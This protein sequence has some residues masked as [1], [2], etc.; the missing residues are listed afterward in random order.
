MLDTGCKYAQIITTQSVSPENNIDWS[1]AT[2]ANL[3]SDNGQYA[4]VALD[5]PQISYRLKAQAFDFSAVPDG[6]TINGI[7]VE[8]DRKSSVANTVRDYRVQLLDA[9]GALV[10]SSKASTTY[11]PTSD[12]VATYGSSGD[13]WSASPTAAMVK[14]SDFGVVL[15]VKCAGG[16]FGTA[17]VDYIRMTVYYTEAVT[18]QPSRNYYPHILAH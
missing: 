14:D 1:G 6:A 3:N 5:Y 2:V 15:S 4:T 17:S 9:S 10:G 12:T 13:T 18:F 11:Y 7:T 8:I 16:D